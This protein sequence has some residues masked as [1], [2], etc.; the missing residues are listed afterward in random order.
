M[1][2]IHCFTIIY[3]FFGLNLRFIS[4]FHWFFIFLLIHL[5]FFSLV[6]RKC[7]G[8]FGVVCH[9]FSELIYIFPLSFCKTTSHLISLTF[10]NWLQKIFKLRVFF[11]YRLVKASKL[12]LMFLT[13]IIFDYSCLLSPH[14]SLFHVLFLNKIA[15]NHI[16]F[17]KLLQTLISFICDLKEEIN[18]GFGISYMTFGNFK[19]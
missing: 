8:L 10:K 15:M 2:L 4:P 19:R 17:E 5:V 13:S 18:I 7:R 9:I 6:L 3:N 14:L 1:K 12:K 16:Y 11:I